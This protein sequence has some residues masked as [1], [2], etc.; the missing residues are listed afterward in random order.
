MGGKG[1][2]TAPL[3]G[4]GFGGQPFDPLPLVVIGLGHGTVGL[5][6]AGGRNPFILKVN[7]GLGPQFFFQKI[8]ADQRRGPPDRPDVQDLLRD[9]DMAVGTHFLFEKPHRENGRHQI[10]GQRLIGGGIQRRQQTVGNIGNDVVPLGYAFVIGKKNL[11]F[12]HTPLGF[13]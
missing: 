3:A 8:G 4:A 10:R 6:A 5:V 11:F 1:Q 9:I 13:C 7:P 2:G 12:H